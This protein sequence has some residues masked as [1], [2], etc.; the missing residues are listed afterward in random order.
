MPHAHVIHRFHF[1]SNHLTHSFVHAVV[2]M[3]SI[4]HA[5]FAMAS[6]SDALAKEAHHEIRMD[7]SSNQIASVQGSYSIIFNCDGRP[8]S[9]VYT[10]HL[11]CSFLPVPGPASLAPKVS[12]PS[13]PFCIIVFNFVYLLCICLCICGQALAHHYDPEAFLMKWDRYHITV[14]SGMVGM[15]E[16][17]HEHAVAR[18]IQG[19]DGSDHGRKSFI[20]TGGRTRIIEEHEGRRNILAITFRNKD[21]SVRAIVAALVPT[22]V[23]MSFDHAASA[24]TSDLFARRLPSTFLR[25]KPL[26]RETLFCALFPLTACDH[27]R[28]RIFRGGIRRLVVIEV[29][30]ETLSR[31]CMV[32]QNQ[33]HVRAGD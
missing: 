8:P 28:S 18:C 14:W 17:S 23:H 9:T 32:V 6:M 5:A 10:E 29:K 27:E 25:S 2:T 31:L 3:D 24:P 22:M 33:L 26:M 1:W 13:N 4:Q 15:A 7:E 21:G 16:A 11:P 20:A 12:K 30:T 19:P